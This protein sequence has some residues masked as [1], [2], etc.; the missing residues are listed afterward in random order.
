MN[1]F[2]IHSLYCELKMDK[3]FFAWKFNR[4]KYKKQR[5]NNQ[6]KKT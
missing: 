4:D 6:N 3:N 2:N 5:A 1:I